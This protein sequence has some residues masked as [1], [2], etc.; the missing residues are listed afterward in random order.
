MVRTVSNPVPGFVVCSSSPVTK[1]YP[2][3]LSPTDLDLVSIYIVGLIILI[4]TS[5]PAA[6]EQGAGLPGLIVS[7]VVVGTGVGG[8]KATI[9][10]FIGMS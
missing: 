4:T 10:P 5:I 8:V 2:G 1:C 9:G 6:L 3:V 7:M